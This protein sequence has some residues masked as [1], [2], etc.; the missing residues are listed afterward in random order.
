MLN[1]AE[2][3]NRIIR[4]TLIESISSLLVRPWFPWIAS[5][6]VILIYGTYLFVTG[7]HLLI[8]DFLGHVWMA[9]EER[10]GGLGSSTNIVAPAGY[11]ILLNLLHM[12]GLQYMIAGRLLTLLAAIPLLSLVWSAA[13]KLGATPWAGVLA[14]L[15]T[16]TSYHFILTLATPLPDIIALSMTMPLIVLALNPNRSLISLVLAAGLSGLACSVR[17][18]FLQSIVPLSVLLVLIAHP[19][20]WQQRGREVLALISGLVLGLLPETI[21]ALRIGH[22]PF[23]SASKY[24]LT[25]LVGE[26]DYLMTGTQLLNMPST[27]DYMTQHINKILYVAGKAYLQRA[28]IFVLAPAI[29]WWIMS[30]IEKLTHQFRLDNR[31]RRCLM[32]LLIFEAVLMLPISLRQPLPY[33]VVPMLSSFAFIIVAVPAVRLLEGRKPF[34]IALIIMLSI[35]STLQVRSALSVL[36]N[37]R[38]YNSVIAAELRELGISDSAEVLNLV[39]PFELYWPYGDRAPLF[40]YTIKEPGWLALTN[41]LK[42]K[43]PFIYKITAENLKQFRV[44]LT[45][46]ISSEFKRGFLPMFHP[47]EQIGFVQI[48]YSASVSP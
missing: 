27:F 16:A 23:Q 40:Y 47:V 1:K 39:A 31:I 24:Y 37:D 19:I 32:A 46:P 25:L 26:T 11:P 48:Y 41:T 10:E 22:I 7:R 20:P 21:F 33:Y 14:W 36:N 12:S 15:A 35:S 2:R 3:T 5:T 8:N 18:N 44:V 13:S 30:K 42:Q 4:V 17:Y 6:I 9:I 45:P 38:T 28:L 34:A 29:V 43:R